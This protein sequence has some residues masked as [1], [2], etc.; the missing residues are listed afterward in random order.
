[1]GGERIKL[2]AAQ[3]EREELALA[4]ERL[5]VL[6][7]ELVTPFIQNL[8]FAVRR[9]IERSPLPN[10]AKDQIFRELSSLSPAQIVAAALAEAKQAKA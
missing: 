4:R 6:P 1:M 5:D 9:V 2:T 3:R 7:T 8:F 10:E